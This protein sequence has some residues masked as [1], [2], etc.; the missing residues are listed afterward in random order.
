MNWEKAPKSTAYL[1]P[2]Y[3]PLK[4][5]ASQTC[6]EYKCLALNLRLSPP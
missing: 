5:S 6:N 1:E 4:W 2:T 3:R